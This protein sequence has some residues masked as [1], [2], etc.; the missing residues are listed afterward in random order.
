MQ[1][2]WSNNNI[3]RITLLILVTLAIVFGVA[4][5]FMQITTILFYFIIAAIISLIG[6]PICDFIEHLK[7]G[8]FKIPN[9]L[10]SLIAL[11][12]I[13]C[14][15]IGIVK[16]FTPL[17]VEQTNVIAQID[18][19]RVAAGLQQQM[20]NLDSLIIRFQS[21]DQQQQ[22]V[23]Q[24]INE[25]LQE[26]INVTS[27]T[28]IFNNLLGGLGNIIIAIFS[29][30]FISF[31]FLRDEQLFY[32]IV[33]VLTPTKYE[34]NAK[35][36]MHTSKKYLTR[37]FVGLIVQSLV[38]FILIAIGLFVLGFGQKTWLIALFAAIVNIIPYVGPIIGMFFGMLIGVTTNLSIDP[39]FNVTP[40]L[41]QLFILFQ[42]VQLI[43][44][45][46]S[47]PIIYSN[48]IKAHPLEVFFIVLV[49]G[50]LAGVPGM[51]AAMPVYAFFRIIARE[52]FSEF[53]LV[54]KMT[55]NLE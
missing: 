14:C 4:W 8:R 10:S 23:E 19:E 53:K 5:L 42:G 33:M 29:I 31:F 11:A 17:V 50:T 46:I 47:Q 35:R 22:S 6:K 49:F 55:E 52:F 25:N 48:S 21:A 45:F 30:T 9:A 51:I 24:I 27:I 37:Y 39:G 20:E 40:L 3:V 13:Y 7:I 41:I 36:I 28:H 2:N 26:A 34:P 15:I 1:S 16:I 12:V 32:N 54:R 38:V 43:D 44:N 18:T